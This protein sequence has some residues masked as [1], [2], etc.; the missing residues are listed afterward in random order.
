MPATSTPGRSPAPPSKHRFSGL[1]YTI[2]ELTAG[3]LEPLETEPAARTNR[4]LL[5]LDGFLSNA[6]ESFVTNFVNPFA[7]AM[8]ANNA[9]I[10]L[11]NASINLAAALGLMPGARLS[12][13][14]GQRKRVVILTGGL[15]GRLLLLALA[16]V[17]LLLGNQALLYTVMALFALRSFVNQLGYPAW[18]GLVAELVPTSIRGRY[19]GARNIGLAVA[20]LVFT[21]VAGR[22]IE[23][24][25]GVPGYQA[26]LLA[27][28]VVGLLATSVFGRIKEPPALFS[29]EPAQTPAGGSAGRFLLHRQFVAFTGIALVWNLALMIAAPF[30]SVYLIRSLN[31]TPTIIGILAAAYS[32]GNIVGQRFWG[33]LND[34][35]GAA[36]VMRLT[37]LLIPIIPVGWSLAPGP[38][39]LI[40]IEVCSGFLW[41][42]YQLA[43]FNL[44]LQLSPQGQRERFVAIYQTVVF[45]AACVGPLIGAGLANALTIRPLMWISAAGRLIAAVAFLFAI[46]VGRKA[47]P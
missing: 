14:I 2:D 44:L 29:P 1:R 6:S 24:V 35:R 15:A 16:A 9:Q 41:G 11:L 31:G 43:T 17:P 37:G 47:G 26:A 46:R 8:G 45:G 7:M 22:I 20:A 25:G 21:P 39:Y 28:G 12:E 19:F 36:S 4:R 40:P 23:A 27:A 33:R 10:G 3:P 18:S 30:F 32:V 5:W 38:W 13:R 42:G 34:Q